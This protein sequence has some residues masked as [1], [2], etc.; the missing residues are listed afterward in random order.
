MV[1]V[2][3]LEVWW[4]EAGLES[5]ELG[6]QQASIWVY[7][8][9]ALCWVLPS[10]QAVLLKRPVDLGLLLEL[11][12]RVGG[13]AGCVCHGECWYVQWRLCMCPNAKEC[14][15]MQEVQYESQ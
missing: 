7:R 3:R 2:E 6:I 12:K 9:E 4:W 1:L 11:L 5:L 13:P 10:S 14:P 15:K 8:A